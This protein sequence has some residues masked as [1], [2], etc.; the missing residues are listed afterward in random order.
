M[1]CQKP[2]ERFPDVAFEGLLLVGVPAVRVPI[3]DDKPAILEGGADQGRQVSGMICRK[4]ERFSNRVH[5]LGNGSPYLV[6]HPCRSRFTGDDRGEI[7]EEDPQ[8]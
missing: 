7:R 2:F 5:P 4:E 6:T 8:R 1:E 3:R